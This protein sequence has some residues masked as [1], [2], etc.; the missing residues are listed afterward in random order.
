M[1]RWMSADWA[2]K[3]ATVPYAEFGDPQSLNL[4]GYVRNNPMR[5]FDP[6][7][8]DQSVD[9]DCMCPMM[10]RPGTHP[11]VAATAMGIA[12]VAGL[13]PVGGELAAGSRGL[14]TAIPALWA[15]AKSFFSSP[16]G[17][18]VAQNLTDALAPPGT[19]SFSSAGSWVAESVAGRSA[20]ALAYDE[21]ITGNVGRVFRVNGVNFDG[22]SAA[23]LLEAKGP[24]YEKLL[25][26]SFG[27][28][29]AEKLIGQAASQ[30]KAANGAPITW[31]FAE[32]GA[33]NAVSALFKK[34]G[35]KGIDVVYTPAK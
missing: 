4:Y 17:Q 24:G 35:I 31:N 1:G 13:V 6:T 28:S 26:S 18:G 12:G 9:M 20:S 29:V 27:S 2:E 7:G 3:P 19:P 11:N 10:G 33:A 15:A 5:R 34:Q 30:I 14:A 21:Q 22:V 8:H 25:S 16:A 23:G 32:E